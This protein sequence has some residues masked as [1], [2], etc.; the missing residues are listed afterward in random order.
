M[1]SDVQSALGL[2]EAGPAAL[3]AGAGR[4]AGRAADRRVALVVQRVIRQVTLVDPPPQ[5]LL[6]PVEERVVLPDPALVVPLDRLGA[7][8]RRPLLA[9]DA[10][11][12]G[13]GAG[14]R[15]LQRG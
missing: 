7:C 1:S 14:Q 8:P 12:P 2:G 10:G 15:A 3:P 9:A 4:R 6:G 11:D 5:V 13:V